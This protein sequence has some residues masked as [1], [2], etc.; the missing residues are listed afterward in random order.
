MPTSVPTG[1]KA[2]TSSNGCT[3]MARALHAAFTFKQAYDPDGEPYVVDRDRVKALMA[4]NAPGKSDLLAQVNAM[5]IQER[6]I[7]VMVPSARF[8]VPQGASR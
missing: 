8:P 7:Q 1:N 4:A 6:Q 3:T 5:P 2:Q